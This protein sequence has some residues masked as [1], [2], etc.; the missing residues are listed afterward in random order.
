MLDQ[1]LGDEAW[2]HLVW[3]S[4]PD[5]MALSDPEGIV[6]MAN[7]AYSELYG[8]D[9]DEVVGRSFAIIFPPEVREQALDHYR[10]VFE[11]TSGTPTHEV[12]IRRKDGS[13][14]FVQ[15]R[16]EVI[17]R[18]GQRRAMLSIIRDIT[19]R[20]VT[21]RMQREF[22]AMASHELKNP[23]TMVKGFA[24]LMRRRGAYNERAV[25]SI[26]SQAEHMDRLLGDL[27]DVARLESGRL[28]IVR[29]P[30]D[31]VELVRACTER[32]R[33]QAGDPTLR[34]EASTERLDGTWDADRLRQVIDNLLSN[35]VKY[36]PDGGEIIVRVEAAG[37]LARVS[38]R[39]HG[40]GIPAAALGS[41]FDRFYRAADAAD[42]AAG[43]G[44]GLFV[45][46]SI[47]D[48]HGGQIDVTSE[49]GRGSKFTVSLPIR[50]EAE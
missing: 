33:W 5:A 45:A 2:L 20:R 1:V 8:Y 48:L 11:G 29:A 47:V 41:I 34:F 35:A 9:T 28:E 25:E 49:P 46:K 3:E 15:A 16:A 6:L 27:L 26:I 42:G 21:E 39:D 13:E 31:L 36:S 10:A 24:Q 43:F 19:E 37:P 40:V 18:D 32:A 17:V 7:P 4:A 50:M 14:R 38:V 22:L 44:I 23:L 12:V 30:V